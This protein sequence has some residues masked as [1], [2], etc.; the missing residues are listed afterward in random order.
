MIEVP[1]TN[2]KKKKLMQAKNKIR[3]KRR[4]KKYKDLDENIILNKRG[5]VKTEPLMNKYLRRRASG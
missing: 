4:R 1:K 5:N 3:M 2:E